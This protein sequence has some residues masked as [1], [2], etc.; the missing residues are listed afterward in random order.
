MGT[1]K[2]IFFISRYLLLVTRYYQAAVAD[3]EAERLLLEKFEKGCV[4]DTVVFT[5]NRILN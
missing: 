1:L 3:S 2:Y 4:D 5:C